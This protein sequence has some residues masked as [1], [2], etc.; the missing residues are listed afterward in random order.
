M[1]SRTN[2]R[3]FICENTNEEV[4]IVSSYLTRLKKYAKAGKYGKDIFCPYCNHS[5]RVYH[6]NWTSLTCH[7]CEKSFKRSEWWVSSDPTKFSKRITLCNP[8][9]KLGKSTS[10]IERLIRLLNLYLENKDIFLNP[11][12]ISNPY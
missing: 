1:T 4:R 10:E 3:G 9:V 8:K 2:Y 6:F 7:Q 11:L 12:L 5:H